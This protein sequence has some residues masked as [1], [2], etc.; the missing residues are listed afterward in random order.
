MRY[1]PF[2]TYRDPDRRKEE[3]EASTEPRWPHVDGM[4][5]ICSLLPTLIISIMLRSD[6]IFGLLRLRRSA[7]RVMLH[8]P[9]ST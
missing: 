1:I 2:H 5:I 8:D 7:G 9:N 6:L 3:E 4:G